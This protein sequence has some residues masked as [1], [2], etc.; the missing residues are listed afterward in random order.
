MV[1]GGVVAGLS[2][3]LTAFTETGND[4]MACPCLDGAMWGIAE[5][6]PAT[7]LKVYF[8]LDPADR[9]TGTAHNIANS[10]VMNH[11]VKGFS[12]FLATV[13]DENDR[14]QFLTTGMQYG[15]REPPGDFVKWM[16]D[17]L[18]TARYLKNNF[19]RSESRR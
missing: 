18:E 7:A 12:E 6:S 13:T 10:T 5:T 4:Q 3:S 19:A 11:G 2:T 15:M 16:A 1:S 17:P 14:K 8:E 9:D